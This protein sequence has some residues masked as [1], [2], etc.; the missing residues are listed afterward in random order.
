MIMIALPQTESTRRDTTRKNDL[1]RLQTQIEFYATNHSGTYPPE[2]PASSLDNNTDF[3]N[4][5]T[6]GSYSP[7]HF[8]DPT[9][10]NYWA[11]NSGTGNITYMLGH[12][13][14][15]DGS[16]TISSLRQFVLRMTLEHG[17][18]CLDNL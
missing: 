4:G 3:G 9:V 14:A 7:A 13:T 10:G 11:I 12:G 1:A 17:T 18:A 5:G 2:S 15:C 8:T 16:T 6:P